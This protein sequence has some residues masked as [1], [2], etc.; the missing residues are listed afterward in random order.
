MSDAK[1]PLEDKVADWLA[2]EGYRLEYLTTGAL[3]AEGFNAVMSHYVE[4]PEGKPREIDVTA[5]EIDQEGKTPVAVRVLCECKYSAEN[6]WIILQSGLAADLYIDWC[7]LPKSNYLQSLSARVRD[8]GG[9]L[10]NN[11]HFAEG[12]PFGHNLVQAF[13]RDNRDAAYESLQKI[14]NAAWD[15]AD[16]LARHRQF[17]EIIVIPCLVVEAPL[18]VAA[19][20]SGSGQF[21][22]KMVP[23]GRLSWAGCRDATAV[24]VVH[25]SA[26]RDYARSLKRT[27]ADLLAVA[28]AILSSTS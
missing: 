2:K 19:F 3:R 16:L 23:A 12:Q 10:R 26:L 14:A 9:R 8:H 22:V 18:C 25:V 6:P 21:V 1:Q 5:V 27:F 24:D 17:G 11:W 7:S 4:T 28:R 13:K 20:D 15:A